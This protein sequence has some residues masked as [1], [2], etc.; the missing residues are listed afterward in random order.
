[1]TLLTGVRPLLFCI[2]LT[3][4]TTEYW[5]IITGRLNCVLTSV[6]PLFY[7]IDRCQTTILVLTFA[8]PIF[9]CVMLTGVRPL[10]YCVVL[11]GVAPVFYCVV[12]T[13][14]RPLF[15]C[16]VLTG[17]RPLFKGL[18]PTLLRTVP[19]TGGLFLAYETTKT[20]LSNKF[21][22]YGSVTL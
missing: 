20:F 11:T 17:V 16:V 2:V 10:F 4:I 1:M 3:K 7:C 18:G 13:G 12:L 9:Y 5:S 8:S 15:Y 21:A 19:A 14:V 22:P 6:R